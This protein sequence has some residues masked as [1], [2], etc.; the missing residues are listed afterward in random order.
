MV[1]MN[2]GVTRNISWV[3]F[4]RTMGGVNKQLRND[5]AKVLYWREVLTPKTPSV[6]TPLTM[7][8]KQDGVIVIIHAAAA[9]AEINLTILINDDKKKTNIRV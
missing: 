6:A 1:T 3:G 2:S 9:A 7:K 4:L 8:Y 5:D